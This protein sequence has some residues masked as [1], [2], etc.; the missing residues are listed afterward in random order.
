MNLSDLYITALLTILRLSFV[1][2]GLFEQYVPPEGD[3]KS[4]A[5]SKDG[6]KQRLTELEKRGKSYMELRKIRKYEENFD[7]KE[8][9]QQAQLLYIETHKLMEDVKKNEDELHDRITE[10]AYPQMMFGL[11]LKSLRWNFIESLEPPRVVHIRTTELMGKEN[12]YA[13]V[14]VRMHT[15]QTLAI[16]DRFGR[17]MFGSEAIVKDILEYV[18]LEKHIVNEYGLW[19]IHG[20]IVPD[21]MPPREPLIKSYRKPAIEPVLEDEPKTEQ[22]EVEETGQSGLATA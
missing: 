6:A 16:Y 17:L 4:S 14:T 3:G 7:T 1:S 18:V 19:R 9:A 22:V 13:Q 21:W 8:F 20:K 11:E 12:L 2:G 5:I 15:K 10:H